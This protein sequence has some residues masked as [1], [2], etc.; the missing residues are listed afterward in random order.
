MAMS[1]A[2]R[3]SGLALYGAMLALCLWLAALAS[4]ENLI[5]LLDDLLR[6]IIGQVLLFF[7]AWAFWHHLFGGVKHLLMDVGLF[8]DP[9]QAKRVACAQFFLAMLVNLALWI[10]LWLAG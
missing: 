7:T 3:L 8:F 5:I 10:N 6:S 2:H 4:G 1:I 9:K